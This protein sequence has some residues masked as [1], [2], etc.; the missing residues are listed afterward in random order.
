MDPIHV[1][2][3]EGRDVVWKSGILRWLKKTGTKGSVCVCACVCMYSLMLAKLYVTTRE[4]PG[5]ISG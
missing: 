4:E 1:L 5:L 2:G 3:G